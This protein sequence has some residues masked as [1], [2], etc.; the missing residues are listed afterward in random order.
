MVSFQQVPNLPELLIQGKEREYIS[1]FFK[2]LA[3]NPSEITDNDIKVYVNHLSGT[4]GLKGAFDHFRSFSIDVLQNKEFSTHKI[5]IPVLVLGG[6]FYPSL[7]DHLP[8]NFAL[9]SVQYLATNV[10]GIIVP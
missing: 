10:K 3:Y 4:G 1:W 9:E 8:S 6:E 5:T 7:G 2:E